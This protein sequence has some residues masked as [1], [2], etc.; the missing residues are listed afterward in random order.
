MKEAL[1]AVIDNLFADDTQMIVC[2]CYD[3]NTASAK[4]LESLGFTC[5]GRIHKSTNHPQRGVI[6]QLSWYLEKE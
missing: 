3:Y 6:D 2:T 1:R 4:T 5:E